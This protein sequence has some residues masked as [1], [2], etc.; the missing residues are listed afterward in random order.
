MHEPLLV[1][2]SAENSTGNLGERRTE[3]AQTST[4]KINDWFP[5]WLWGLSMK[6]LQAASLQPSDVLSQRRLVVIARL[7]FFLLSST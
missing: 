5:V 7:A 6:H 4:L 3:P 1:N 2:E